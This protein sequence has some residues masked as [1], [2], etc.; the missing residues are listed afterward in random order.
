M[1]SRGLWGAG[2][3]KH[4]EG[5]EKRMEMDHLHALSS[6]RSSGLLTH[7]IYRSQR[8]RAGGRRQGGEH[9]A[10]ENIADDLLDG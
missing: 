8:C 4:S 3:G 9:R 2:S 5:R 7:C 10:D 6:R 1:A